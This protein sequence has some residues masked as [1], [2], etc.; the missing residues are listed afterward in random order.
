MTFHISCARNSSIQLLE[1]DHERDKYLESHLLVPM[2]EKMGQFGND[3]RSRD[4]V[5]RE[6]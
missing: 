2:S 3:R 6:L 5:L 4:P 1:H